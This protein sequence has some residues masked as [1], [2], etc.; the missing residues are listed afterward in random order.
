MSGTCT[1]GAFT[2][3][4]DI[5]WADEGSWLPVAQV[6]ATTITG[7]LVV[8][9]SAMQAGRPITLIARGDKHVWVSYAEAIALRE[10]AAADVGASM[11]LTLIDGRTFNVIWD[12]RDKAVEFEPVEYVVSDNDDENDAR[13]YTLTLRLMQ[14]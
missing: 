5:E 4:P 10:A 3:P 12:H 11:L 9:Q 13:P 7:A 1:L 8:Q 6:I 14:V 2:L